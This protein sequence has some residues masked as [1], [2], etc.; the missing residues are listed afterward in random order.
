MTK[1]KIFFDFRSGCWEKPW[2]WVHDALEQKCNVQEIPEHRS[3][4]VGNVQEFPEHRFTFKQILKIFPKIDTDFKQCSGLSWTLLQIW[5]D[6]QEHLENLVKSQAMFRKFLNIAKK[7]PALVLKF[8]NK[9][10][11]LSSVSW[12]VFLFVCCMFLHVVCMFVVWLLDMFAYLLMCFACFIMFVEC[13][14]MLFAWICQ[15][16][17]CFCMICMCCL[18]EF[19][20]V[21]MVF[22][23]FLFGVQWF[24]YELATDTNAKTMQQY[25]NT[26]KIN[27]NTTRKSMFQRTT[28][29]SCITNMATLRFCHSTH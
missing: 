22:A 4:F 21:W 15:E 24:Y 14:C 16:L 27:A 11:D 26:W 8:P 12:I 2:S 18:L 28:I 1:S 5:R 25:R 17:A 29:R 20:I 23:L 13:G 19:G 6:F 10:L 3:D 9:T 7:I